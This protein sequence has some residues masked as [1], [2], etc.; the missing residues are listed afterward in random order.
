MSLYRSM[1]NGLNA[2][3]AHDDPNVIVL[4]QQRGPYIASFMVTRHELGILAETFPVD[5]ERGGTEPTTCVITH[6]P[7]RLAYDGFSGRYIGAWN[8]G[9]VFMVDANQMQQS[10]AAEGKKL[11]PD[12]ESKWLYC[13]SWQPGM[14]GVRVLQPRTNLS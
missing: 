8:N 12:V 10:L 9:V 5:P 14:V 6:G 3:T 4:S 2:E 1:G 11:T 7:Q 13:A